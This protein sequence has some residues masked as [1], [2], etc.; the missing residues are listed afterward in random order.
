MTCDLGIAI[1]RH[2]Q[3][4]PLLTY[5]RLSLKT[6]SLAIFSRSLGSHP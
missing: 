1:A 5:D 6:E 4:L 2:M 3:D